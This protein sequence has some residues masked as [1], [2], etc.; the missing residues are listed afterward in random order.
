MHSECRTQNA[1]CLKPLELQF[2]G[3]NQSIEV[4][5][6]LLPAPAG[7]A[8][9]AGS[10]IQA[11]TMRAHPVIGMA[12]HPLAVGLVAIAVVAAR[13]AEEV[14]LPRALVDRER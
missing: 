1:E 4:P 9:A 14:A 8:E 6:A 12:V 13:G 7:V 2:I 3:A 11:P 5:W 10:V